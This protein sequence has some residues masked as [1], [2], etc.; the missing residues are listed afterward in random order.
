MAVTTIEQNTDAPEPSPEAAAAY[1]WR[2]RCSGAPRPTRSPGRRPRRR[3]RCERGQKP[4]PPSGPARSST[5]STPGTAW[6]FEVAR[7]GYPHHIPPNIT[8]YQLEARAAFFPLLPSPGVGDQQGRPRWRRHG[9]ARPEPRA[10]RGLRPPRRP[11]DPPA[12][13]Q[14]GR[15]PGDGAHRAVPGQLRPELRL[16]RGPHAGARR[17]LPVV[18]DATA[19][20]PRRHP[21]RSGHREPANAIAIVASCVVAAIVAIIQ[22]REWKALL[23]P[24]LAPVGWIAFQLFLAHQTGERDAWFRVQGE[25]WDEGTSFGLTAI[26]DIGNAL[27]HPLDSPR[28]C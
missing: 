28:T 21:R 24:L 27:V 9:R 22:R 26:R 8:F 13:R 5:S 15:V 25:A 20:A 19:L 6:Y 18:P 4:R 1:P 10:G 7:H 14:Q 17:G 23:A 12:L 3:R 11:H 2:G 16:Q